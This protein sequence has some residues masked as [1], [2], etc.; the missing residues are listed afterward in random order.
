MFFVFVFVVG[1]MAGA[2]PEKTNE[3]INKALS[4]GSEISQSA[5][6]KATEITESA[7][8]KLVSSIKPIDTFQL[9][10]LMRHHI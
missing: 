2:G 6:T 3:V 1:L 9:K 4:K 7:K 8:S 10:E 5:K